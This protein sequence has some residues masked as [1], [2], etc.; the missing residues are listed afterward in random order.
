M[1]STANWASYVVK[2]PEC[3]QMLLVNSTS[4]ASSLEML[5]QEACHIFAKKKML[6]VTFL[7]SSVFKVFKALANRKFVSLS[8]ALDMYWYLLWKGVEVDK[9]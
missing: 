9:G 3:L 6:S 7:H 1:T 5:F 2:G 4:P 8:C